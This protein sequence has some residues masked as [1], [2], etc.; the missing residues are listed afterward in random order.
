MIPTVFDALLVAQ[1]PERCVGV[2]EAVKNIVFI[3]SILPGNIHSAV[4]GFA[5]NLLR[6]GFG[7]PRF[8]KV[9]RSPKDVPSGN[10]T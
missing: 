9:P 3:F 8:K 10:L 1:L 5:S 4:A 2:K 7:H 6:P